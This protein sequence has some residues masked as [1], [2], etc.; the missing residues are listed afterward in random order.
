MNYKSSFMS[1]FVNDMYKSIFSSY[2]WLDNLS[3]STNK[4]LKQQVIRVTVK[5]IDYVQNTTV[6]SA[7]KCAQLC[8]V[9]TSISLPHAWWKKHVT[10]VLFN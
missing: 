10:L 7:V 1:Y 4:D 2:I 8:Q 5:N 6:P 9:K 3:N